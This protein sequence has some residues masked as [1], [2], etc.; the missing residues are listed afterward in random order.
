[1]T[2]VILICV[3]TGYIIVNKQEND[4]RKCNIIR[5]FK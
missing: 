2:K 3:N 5:C 1:M 4:V